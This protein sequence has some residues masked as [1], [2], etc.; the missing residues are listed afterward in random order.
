MADLL[1][2]VTARAPTESEGVVVV[3]AS[4]HRV[5]VKSPAYVA[6]H[7]LKDSVANSPRR[8]LELILLGREDDAFP[9]LPTAVREHGELMR[10]RYAS[11]LRRIDDAYDRLFVE[12]V[13]TNPRKAFALAVQREKLPIAPLMARYSGHCTSLRG[14]VDGRRNADGSWPDGFLDTLM[15]IC[16]ITAAEGAP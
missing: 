11:A 4:F 6:L 9:L 7:G 2:I 13:G 5:K 12:A 1:A 16:D 3:D 8:L 10:A 15:D 14:W